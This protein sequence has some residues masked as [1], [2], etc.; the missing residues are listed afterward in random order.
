MKLSEVHLIHACPEPGRH[1]N[2]ML[3]FSAALGYDLELV[4][5]GIRVEKGGQVRIIAPAAILSYEP[6]PK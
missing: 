6:A 2:T 1:G 5:E 3:W 4:K